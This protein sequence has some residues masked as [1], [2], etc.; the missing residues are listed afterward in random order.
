M[1]DSNN[2]KTKIEK[3]YS[4]AI[5]TSVGAILEHQIQLLMLKVQE[6][7]GRKNWFN[8]YIRYFI[9]YC[10]FFSPIIGLV[11]AAATAPL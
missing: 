10:I 3:H 5:A 2:F 6:L 1:E 4:D 11:P 9:C 8:K 7:K